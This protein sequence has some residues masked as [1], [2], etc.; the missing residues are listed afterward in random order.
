M[1]SRDWPNCSAA[2]RLIS[3]YWRVLSVLHRDLRRDVVDDLAEEGVV[4]VAFLFRIE[5][6]GDLF[7]RGDP[8]RPARA[9][10]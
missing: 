9:A 7:D 10:C 5:P 2:V 8:S 6:L 4:A 1:A 3:R